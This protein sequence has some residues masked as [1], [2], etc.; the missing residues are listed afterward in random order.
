MNPAARRLAQ[1]AFFVLSV[2]FILLAGSP[3]VVQRPVGVAYLV[4]WGLMA[5]ATAV[6]R[7]P[8]AP[9]RYDRSQILW[10]SVLGV[11]AFL[12]ILVIGP[13]E[14]THL[15]GPLPRDG[16][17]AWLGIGLFALGTLI[18]TWAMATLRSLYTVRLS[19][20]VEHRLVTS[21]PYRVVRHPGYFGFTL[22]LPGMGL[23]LGSLAILAAT[24]PTLAW[25]V[26]RMGK[27][28]A[29]LLEQFGDEYRAYQRRTKR[30]IPF[31]Y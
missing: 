6:F 28:E 31:V 4:L 16:L 24:V 22:A 25:I 3:E 30:L 10:R 1:A 27:E 7:Q 9:S 23:A 5:F 2:V 20:Q 18:N 19:V 17:L 15:A 21:G 11:I 14:Y 29:M 12:T 8:G 26:E 13:W